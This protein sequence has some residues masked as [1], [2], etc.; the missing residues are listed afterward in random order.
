MIA[1]KC[2]V[3]DNEVVSQVRPMKQELCRLLLP[4]FVL[5]KVQSTPEI[6]NVPI[7][8]DT[9]RRRFHLP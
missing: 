6:F 8:E 9:G 5:A 1:E 7:F 4:F 2:Q 3:E